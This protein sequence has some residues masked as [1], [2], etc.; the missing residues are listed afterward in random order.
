MAGDFSDKPA[1]EHALAAGRWALS[2]IHGAERGEKLQLEHILKVKSQVV[3][4]TRHHITLRPDAGS[5]GAALL[6]V[7]VWERLPHAWGSEG[8]YQLNGHKEAAE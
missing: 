8:R 5:G 2:Q 1:D 7:D 4:G 3:A 6:E